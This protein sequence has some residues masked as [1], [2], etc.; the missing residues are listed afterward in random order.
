[1]SRAK[2]LH[3]VSREAPRAGIVHSIHARWGAND[4]ASD[5]V[6]T[7]S[8]LQAGGLRFSRSTRLAWPSSSSSRGGRAPGAL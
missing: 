7:C 5:V 4:P 3:F 1:M 6:H 8:P 2:E